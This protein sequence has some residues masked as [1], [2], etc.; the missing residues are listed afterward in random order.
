M[1]IL[2]I[3]SLYAPDVGG[4]AEIILQRT[5]E[6]LQQRGHKVA[7]LATTDQP[8]LHMTVV[9]QIKV[10]RA[11]LNNLYWHFTAQRPGRLAR[12]GWHLR[13]RYNVGMR[14]Y[15]SR[16]MEVEQPDLVVCHNLTGWSVSAWDEITASGRPIVQVLHDLYLLCPSSTMFKKGH[17]CQRQCVMC[18]QFRKGHDERSTQVSTVVG[19]SRYMLDTLQAEGYFKGAKGYVVHNVSPVPIAAVSHVGVGPSDQAPGTSP[20]RFGYLGTLSDPKGLG[21]LIDQFQHLP[22]DATLQIAGRG[23]LNDEKRFKAMVSSPNISFV[24][25]QK[26]EDFYRQ[27]DVAVVP[28]RWN[29]PFGMVAVEACA[30]SRPVIASRVGGLT[31]IIQDQLNGLL[32]SPDDPDSLGLAMLKLHQQPR[33]LARLSAQARNSVASL[34]SLDLMLD[35]YESIFSQT[36]LD[37]LSTPEQRQYNPV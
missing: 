36:V 31:E 29:E 4:G 2:F 5:V 17:S 14:E 15:V 37:S 33:L 23:Q 26:P 34:L 12:L 16:V 30:Y 7:V 1:N 11:G 3:S 20:L 8:G 10:Y 19:V 35:Q 6:G 24:G 9:N 18:K 21:W 22:F 27:I 28:S 32:C 25:Y 13:D